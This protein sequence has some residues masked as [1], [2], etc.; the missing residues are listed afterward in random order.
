MWGTIT[1]HDFLNNISCRKPAF[2]QV[3]AM[4]LN[5]VSSAIELWFQQLP[6]EF[7]V[8]KC[9][10]YQDKRFWFLLPNNN[11]WNLL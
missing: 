7:Q 4:Q 6:S 5:S 2:F 3:D 8:K 10:E 9:E 1:N 11:I